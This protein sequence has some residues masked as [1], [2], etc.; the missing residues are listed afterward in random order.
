MKPLIMIVEDSELNLLMLSRRLRKNQFEI[1][2]LLRGEQLAQICRTKRPDLV[3]MDMCLPGLDGWTLTRQLK[4]NPATAALPV[5]AVTACAMRG[6]E[7]RAL[8]A[9]CDGY[10]SK[11]IDFPRLLRM[12][13]TLLTPVPTERLAESQVR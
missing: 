11:P 2:E 12:I 1:I 7:E 5:I 9:G 6:D 3:L 8:E 4:A 13:Q 10:I